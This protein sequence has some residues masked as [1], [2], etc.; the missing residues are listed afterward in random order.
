[1]SEHHQ[2]SGRFHHGS[3]WGAFRAVV[4]DGRITGVESFEKDRVPSPLLE[5]IPD[6][7]HSDSRVDQ[8]HVRAG[9]LE[10]GPG[11]SREARGAEPFV[12]VSWDE[13]LDLVSREL[14]RVRGDFGNEAIYAGSY[15]WASAGRVHHAKTALQRFLNGF[16]GFTNSVQSYSVAAAATILPYVLGDNGVM[17]DKATSWD[18]I[19]R[20][21]ELFVAFGGLP[22]RNDQV[23]TAGAATHE[24]EPWLKRARRAGVGF[25]NISPNR[26]D[27]ADFLEAEWLAPRPNTD[28]ALMLGLG[29]TLAVEELHDRAFLEHHCSGYEAFEAYLL[30][31]S[32]GQPKT[33]EWAAAIAD[34]EAGAIRDLARRMAAS[35]TFITTSYSLQ[36]AAH[37]EQP[38]WMTVVLAAMLGQIGL[39]GGGFGLGHGSIAG[40]GMPRGPMV[41][42][43]MQAGRNPVSSFIPVA[44][45][46]DM[47]LQPG[48]AYDFNGE[49]RRYPEI[50]L[51]YWCGGN[52]FH[53]HQDLNRLIEAWRRPETVIVHEP[54]WTATA[55]HADIVLPATTT[56]ERNDLSVGER[57][58]FVIAMHRAI[59]PQGQARNDFEI[60]S[61]LAERLGF[62]D[63][64]TEGRDEM[65]WIRHLYDVARQQAARH[66]L[67]WPDF[68][69]FWAAGH[70]EVPATGRPKIFLEAFRADPAA[71]PL[72][73]PS[74]RIEIHSEKVASFGYGVRATDS[75][76]SMTRSVMSS[77]SKPRASSMSPRLTTRSWP[78]LMTTSPTA[79][80]M[81]CR[82]RADSR[83]NRALP[84]RTPSLSISCHSGVAS[85]TSS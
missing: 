64:Y 20:D 70:V 71:H 19:A 83:V 56:L 24:L 4:E 61:G 43:R 12:R 30:G 66:Q 10:H 1:M 31:Q 8:P 41:V 85:H 77:T 74:G 68:E 82:I 6:A 40:M 79:A 35:R 81:R 28:T 36:R 51:V 46:A 54:W 14:T 38:Y 69:S 34:I 16:G 9:W 17:A 60:F 27:M 50:R 2:A 5:S 55:R 32:D 84:L 73:T 11:G 23:G 52:P 29:H 25:V 78:E 15:G 26:D 48:Q 21:T 72:A 59:A 3:H 63:A 44:R 13:A 33:P 45:I 65:G 22:L 67:T 7:V 53:H 47:L 39:P 57:D 49:R 80:R 75:N 76:S 37:G 42:P 58:N 62:R 18:G